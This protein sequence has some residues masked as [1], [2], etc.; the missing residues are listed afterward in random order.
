[1]FHSSLNHNCWLKCGAWEIIVSFIHCCVGT[2]PRIRVW[3]PPRPRAATFSSSITQSTR[4]SPIL[5]VSANNTIDLVTVS[6]LNHVKIYI[7]P[8]SLNWNEVC[9]SCAWQ[10]SLVYNQNALPPFRKVPAGPEA[11]RPPKGGLRPLLEP[12][13]QRPPALRQR[14]SHHLPLGHQCHTSGI[15]GQS[16][17]RLVGWSVDLSVV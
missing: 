10:K 7:K 3:S 13:P 5:A 9:C 4:A 14:W 11:A 6:I 8:I 17:R 15:T 12:Q 1:M 2:C 16:V